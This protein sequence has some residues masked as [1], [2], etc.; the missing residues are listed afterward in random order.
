MKKTPSLFKRDYDGTRQLLNEVVPGSEWVHAGEGRAT[1]KY[2]GTSC[3]IQNG[4]FY[5]RYE[6]KKNKNAPDN[7]LPADEN[8]PITGK[9][10]GWIP[11]NENDRAN[12][13][14]VEAVNKRIDYFGYPLTDGT[15]ELCGPKVQGNPEKLDGHWL[16]KH[17]YNS[18][19]DER[20]LANVP[21]D[22]EGLKE[23]LKDYPH[24]GIVWH[25]PDGRKVKIKRKDFD[26]S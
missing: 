16:I 14:H 6:L 24:E 2:D 5:K 9:Q 10:P 11:I 26:Y 4:K 23:F 3:L 18:T 21:T 19:V 1:R 15:Y 20:I 17:G 13:Y 8:D 7:F 25:H 22:F 12:K